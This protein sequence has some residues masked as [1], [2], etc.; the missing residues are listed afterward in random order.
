MKLLFDQNLSPRLIRGIEGAFPGS[1]HVRNVGLDQSTDRQVWEYARDQDFVIVSKDDDFRQLA[2]LHG[3]PPKVVWLRVSN[4][5]TSAVEQLLTTN[6][7][8]ITEFGESGDESLLVL[9]GLVP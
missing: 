4:G 1:D 5:P 3:A 7:S 9:P 8:V 2:F 6:V